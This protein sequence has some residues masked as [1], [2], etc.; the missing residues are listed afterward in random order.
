VAEI[1]MLEN[2]KLNDL[3]ATLIPHISIV[4]VNEMIPDMDQIFI[5]AVQKFNAEHE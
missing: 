1:R 2:R 5:E 3:L 4:S